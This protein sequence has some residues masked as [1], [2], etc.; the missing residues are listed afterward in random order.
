MPR[1]ETPVRLF[2][3]AALECGAEFA[4]TDAQAHYL[5]RVMRRGVG[6]GVRTFNGRDG[7]WLATI[8]RADRRTCALGVTT[9]L[10]RQRSESGPIL[11]FAPIRKERLHFVIE[12]ATELGVAT[13]QPVLTQHAVAPRIVLDRVRAQAIEAAEQCGRLTIP[14]IAEPLQLEA[15][16][17]TWLQDRPLFFLDERGVG[18]TI[19]D[20][21]R[22]RRAAIV[23]SAGDIGILV[24]PEGG[25]TE[26]EATMIA[27]APFVTAISLGP[28]ILR[29]ETAA[30]AALASWRAFTEDWRPAISE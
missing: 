19:A 14:R 25:F 12:K 24:G 13:L 7:E 27:I 3:D 5:T 21:A 26:A 1:A 20:A 22:E 4:V 9:Q 30:I 8:V 10:C 28:L 6:D 23:R 17:A 2:V 11:A 29:A 16:I 18:R 15:L